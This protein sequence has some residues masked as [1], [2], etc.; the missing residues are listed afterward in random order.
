MHRRFGVKHKRSRGK[1][2]DNFST[3]Q[4]TYLDTMIVH[5]TKCG[6]QCLSSAFKF[7]SPNAAFI[8]YPQRSPFGTLQPALGLVLALR[9]ARQEIV[10]SDLSAIVLVDDCRTLSWLGGSPRHRVSRT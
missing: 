4:F 9:T 3:G 1:L 6:F 8:I 7:T 10:G 5:L 2:M